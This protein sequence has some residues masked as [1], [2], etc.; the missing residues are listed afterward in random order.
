MSKGGLEK[1]LDFLSGNDLRKDKKFLSDAYALIDYATITHNPY[2]KE[3][4][5]WRLKTK[6]ISDIF[7]PSAL[8]LNRIMIPIGFGAAMVVYGA[9]NDISSFVLSYFTASFLIAQMTFAK[10]VRMYKEKF[11]EA[12]SEFSSGNLEMAVEKVKKHLE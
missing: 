9:D 1:T 11:S 5:K 10:E 12:V 2:T 8:Y 7:N 3:G 6:A 4:R